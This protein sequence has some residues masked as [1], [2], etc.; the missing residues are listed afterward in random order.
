MANRGI[1]ADKITIIPNA[2]ESDT[3]VF[4]S[5]PDQALRVELGLEGKIVLGFIGFFLRI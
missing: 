5:E 1:A 2:V 4:G 3:F